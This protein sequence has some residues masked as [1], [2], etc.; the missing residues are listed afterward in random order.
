MTKANTEASTNRLDDT[1]LELV[2]GGERTLYE[3]LHRLW[4]AASCVL[5]GSTLTVKGDQLHCS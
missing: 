1:D 3:N 2:S 4:F 5:S